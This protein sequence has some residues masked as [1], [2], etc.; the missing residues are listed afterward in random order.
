MTDFSR[1]WMVIPAFNE[2]Q[3]ETIAATVRSARRVFP[4][5]VVVDDCS[6]D[7]TGEL[8]LREGAHVCRHPVNLGQGAALVTGIRYALLQGADEIV[9]F[10]ADGQHG[11]KDAQTMVNVL[12]AEKVDVVLGS[13]FLGTAS[14]ISRSKRLFLKAATV[15]TRIS[16]G[17]TVTDAHNGLRVL[18]K[19]AAEAIIIRQ[20]RM[21]HASEILHQ[22]ATLGLSYV[23]VPTHITYTD[24][25]VAKGQKMSGAFV[26]LGDLLIQ[27]FHR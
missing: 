22:I 3:H 2:A 11:V 1:T 27:K 14:G 26:I 16:T 9:T 25:S 17:L 4:S 24:Y 6:Q 18:N 8:A 10:D 12:R 21:A 15:F 5:I 20:N 19:S 13:R 7:G 23:E